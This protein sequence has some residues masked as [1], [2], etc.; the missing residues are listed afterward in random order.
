MVKEKTGVKL[1][2]VHAINP[3]NG[4]E[5]PIFASDYVMMGY[6]TGA[7]MAVPGHDQ[8]DWEFATAYGLPIVEV[9]SGGDVAVEAYSGDGILVNSGLING[10]SVPEA[11]KK[12][13]AWLVKQ[14]LGEAKI[15]FKLRDWVFARQRYWGE[16]IPIV[17][18]PTCGMVPLPE[19]QLPLLLPDVESYE[20]TDTGD[21]PLSA[22]REWVEVSC[23]Q[24]GGAA[25]RETDTMPGW[26][27]S[28]WYYL[29]Y[30]DPHN[31][32]ELASKDALAKWAP[33]DWYN[34][35]MEHTTLH[36]LYS[37]FW[38]KFLYDIG[39]VPSIEPYKKRTSHGMILA[40]DG[41]KMSKSR[42]NVVNPDD[43]VDEYGA[44][45]LRLYIMFI[46]DFEKAAS[47][48]S[49]AVKGCR[50]FID[51]VWA[52][53]EK[54]TA[55][56]TYSAALETIIH[57]TIKKVSSDVFDLKFNTAI[58]ALM[59]LSNEMAKCETIA[60]A[61]YEALLL[62]LHPFAPH[63]TEE[64]WSL[65]GNGE[66]LAKAA[67]LCYDE[68][69]VVDAVVTYAVQVN[70]KLRGTI[71]LPTDT[72]QESAIKAAMEIDKVAAH[73]MDSDPK[74]VIFVPG[75]IINLIG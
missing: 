57:K 25:E 23:P 26:A 67:W 42:G 17:H 59:T 73:F 32:K 52:L 51:R 4:K 43:V 21:S 72:T 6:G 48:S 15:N 62:L 37:R 31:S 28:S 7:I 66:L 71:E 12:I 36:L 1:D 16:P 55:G 41:E 65:L 35:G 8:R 46:G 74:K 64:L 14:E 54:V 56:E 33:V 18:C 38:H 10:L 44:D 47:W 50:R 68:V 75:K 70:G 22:L 61:D 53:Q 3:V 29:R 39:V 9:V 40:E 13:T 2:G 60:R 45:T 11:K 20:T 69:L 19:E 63:V 27:G 30:A 58:A 49:Q 24:C 5:I 34:G